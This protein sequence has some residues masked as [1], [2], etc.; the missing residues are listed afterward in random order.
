M[1]EQYPK[2]VVLANGGYTF[3]DQDGK[4]WN[5][6]FETAWSFSDGL[7]MVKL[8]NGYTFINKKGKVWNQRF[9]NAWHFKDGLALVELDDGYT[10]VDKQGKVW[11]QRFKEACPF[12]DGLAPVKVDDSW[13]FVDKQG[14]LWNQRFKY[15]WHFEDG[16]AEIQLMSDEI[17]YVNKQGSI[18]KDE[19][20]SKLRSVYKNPK[21]ILNFP[22]EQF[23]DKEFIALCV[24]QIKSRLIA[25]VNKSK[26][27]DIEQLRKNCTELL[28]TVQIKIQLEYNQIELQ[29]QRKLREQQER[30]Q[31]KEQEQRAKNALIDDITNFG[32]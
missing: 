22:T 13:T 14:N 11:N 24:E 6:K 29:E 31:R 2:L 20:A 1:N 19:L 18:I 8:N 15:A 10:F 28:N 23:K 7:A 12:K 25:D 26:P 3:K 4:L 5:Q 16:L 27:E 21:N 17:C 32:V 30:E 9:K